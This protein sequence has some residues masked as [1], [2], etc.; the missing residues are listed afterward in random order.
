MLSGNLLKVDTNSLFFLL[1][2]YRQLT[3]FSKEQ[4]TELRSMIQ[5]AIVM[6]CRKTLHSE[7]KA[8]FSVD[9]VIGVTMDTEDLLLVTV[10]E[11]NYDLLFKY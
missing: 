4:K 6:L 3:M 11:V 5:K 2:N 7:T 1:Q 9:G 10:N 8:E